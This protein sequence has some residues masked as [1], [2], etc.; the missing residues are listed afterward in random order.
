MNNTQQSTR[1]PKPRLPK[2]YHNQPSTRCM[3]QFRGSDLN[4]ARYKAENFI[5]DGFILCGQLDPDP[6]RRPRIARV[7]QHWD[8][9]RK[10]HQAIAE[11]T[12]KGRF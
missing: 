6:G 2:G 4:A 1:Q 10:A 8:E 12:W 5:A 11:V 7:Y 3:L 9:G